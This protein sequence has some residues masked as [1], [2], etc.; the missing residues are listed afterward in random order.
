MQRFPLLTLLPALQAAEAHDRFH[1]E[2]PLLPG[3]GLEHGLQGGGLAIGRL[4]LGAF[5]E[6]LAEEYAEDLA[7]ALDGQQ[8]GQADAALEVGD[9]DRIDIQRQ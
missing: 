2:L 4:R 9:G 3:Q 8:R 6:E 5:S 7:Q 1:R